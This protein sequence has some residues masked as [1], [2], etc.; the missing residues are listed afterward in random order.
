MSEEEILRAAIS[1]YGAK[2]QTLM[3]FEEMSELMKE[4]CK[5][6][7]GRDNRREIAE[8]IADVRIMLD[9]MSMIYDCKMEE[10]AYRMLKIKR[11]G[12]RLGGK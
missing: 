2:A 4:L 5:H 3:L 10:E 6:A 12:E 9:Q 11:L 8:E 1:T 7:R